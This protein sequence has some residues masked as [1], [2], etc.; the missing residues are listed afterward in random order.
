MQ[1]CTQE[2]NIKDIY[3]IIADLR[4]SDGKKDEQIKTLVSSMKNLVSWVK[5]LVF[6]GI[7]TLISAL[8]FLINYWV[9]GA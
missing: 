7:S 3:K 8:G 1:P 9:K 5:A 4:V 6:V 2:E